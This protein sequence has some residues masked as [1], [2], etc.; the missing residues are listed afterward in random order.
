MEERNITHV[1][2]EPVDEKKEYR[3]AFV[4]RSKADKYDW[5]FFKLE[6]GKGSWNWCAWLFGPAWLVYRKLYMQALIYCACVLGM[7][8]VAFAAEAIFLPLNTATVG[9]SIISI[10]ITIYL[11]LKG[12]KMYFNKVNKCYE[13]NDRDKW[14]RKYGGTS[15]KALILFFVAYIAAIFA[16]SS[17]AA[18]FSEGRVYIEAAITYAI[19]TVASLIV[20]KIFHSKEN[21]NISR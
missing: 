17:I 1:I 16:A 21:E 8:A 11:G 7:Y 20:A 19:I 10:A 5:K 9:A 15:V 14:I 18:L 3:K 2:G 4:G 6:N 12:D 13:S